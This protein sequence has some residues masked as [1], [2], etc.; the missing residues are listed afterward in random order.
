ME[1]VNYEHSHSLHG[2]KEYWKTWTQTELDSSRP[3]LLYFTISKKDPETQDMCVDVLD[4]DIEVIT[5]LGTF[6]S[7][8]WC[9]RVQKL[10]RVHTPLLLQSTIWKNHSRLLLSISKRD[11]CAC[12]GVTWT[13][14]ARKTILWAFHETRSVPYFLVSCWSPLTL[15]EYQINLSRHIALLLKEAY[16]NLPSD[17]DSTSVCNRWSLPALRCIPR[18]SESGQ[19]QLLSLIYKRSLHVIPQKL[20]GDTVESLKIASMIPGTLCPSINKLSRFTYTRQRTSTAKIQERRSSRCGVSDNAF[21]SSV[22]ISGWN[23]NFNR[24]YHCRIV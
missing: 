4:M 24:M 3:E 16:D 19:S 15:K 18:S 17:W 7:I 9:K 2:W 14:P 23:M 11:D 6:I 22:T 1:D 20:L 12:D 5:Y 10:K 13:Q 8:Q 21:K